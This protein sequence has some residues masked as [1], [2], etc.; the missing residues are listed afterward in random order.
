MSGFLFVR[1]LPP[2]VKSLFDGAVAT[3]GEFTVNVVEALM[4]L[5]IDEPRAV[6]EYLRKIKSRKRRER[7]YGRSR[8]T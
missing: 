1:N 3:R 4:R 6:E 5:Y 7:K 2:E 8:L